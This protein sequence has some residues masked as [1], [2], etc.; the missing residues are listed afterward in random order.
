M[1]E[2][3]KI[4]STDQDGRFSQ[5]RFQIYSE[6]LRKPKQRK[7]RTDFPLAKTE[8]KRDEKIISR[9]LRHE[10]MQKTTAAERY[11]ISVKY[12]YDRFSSS[13][14]WLKT[15]EAKSQQY[16]YDFLVFAESLPVYMGRFG[17]NRKYLNENGINIRFI[18]A[19]K[20]AV[21]K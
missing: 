18:S 3:L 7:A 10:M 2:L 12:H 14:E 21:T 19:L 16:F 20:S 17:W 6:Y 1:E 5:K 13:A 9:I 15:P 4:W 8:E 11:L